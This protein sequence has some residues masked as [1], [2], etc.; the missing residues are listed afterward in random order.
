MLPDFLRERV[1][2]ER[3]IARL[4]KE[5]LG[6]GE[7]FGRRHDR[8]G[9][10][11]S[12]IYLPHHLLH[13][14]HARRGLLGGPREFLRDAGGS[15]A[16]L[17]FQMQEGFRQ[18]FRDARGNHAGSDE[19]RDEFR[20]GEHS[21]FGAET[22]SHREDRHDVGRSVHEVRELRLVRHVM[23]EG[24]QELG[25]ESLHEIAD[26]LQYL[27]RRDREVYA[28]L[29]GIQGR[30]YD[31]RHGGGRRLHPLD[32]SPT[33]GVGFFIVPG[34]ALADE[35]FH[36]GFFRSE[37]EELAAREVFYLG[38]YLSRGGGDASPQE[39]ERV[40]REVP[41]VSRSRLVSRSHHPIHRDGHVADGFS[42][43][44]REVRGSIAR[45]V[46]P[47]VHEEILERRS[48]SLSR[49]IYLPIQPS[50]LLHDALL[51][52]LGRV[53]RVLAH[54]PDELGAW[55][56]PDLQE[57]LG[58]HDGFYL[59][60]RRRDE[61]AERV[62]PMSVGIVH[63]E[64]GEAF[65][66]GDGFRVLWGFRVIPVRIR[67]GVGTRRSRI[68]LRRVPRRSPRSKRIQA[69]TGHSET[70]EQVVDGVLKLEVRHESLGTRNPEVLRPDGREPYPI[71]YTLDVPLSRPETLSRVPRGEDG[72]EG[73]LE[74]PSGGHVLKGAIPAFKLREIHLR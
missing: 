18:A 12:V 3:G 64:L 31:S 29:G 52:A 26:V 59:P 10:C 14:P 37:L 21:E 38:E 9:A 50:G 40:P 28:G 27:V 63:E 43:L 22:Q 47:H 6:A 11:R 73:V 30:V 36:G 32:D 71:L 20:D 70:R 67:W 34:D 44:E 42:R 72:S 1:R 25:R 5:G 61:L 53:P 33:D 51:G 8:S 60:L 4:P 24:I 46:L 35:A 17:G 49:P 15:R 66:T 39:V 19:L 16:Y 13:S 41:H 54:L 57:V 74:F 69:V 45:E 58:A 62:E 23:Q 65:G 68:V 2:Y 7:D 48:S 56:L 55:M